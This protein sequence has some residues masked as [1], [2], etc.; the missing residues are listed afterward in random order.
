[1]PL[2]DEPD[3]ITAQNI[4]DAFNEILL[5]DVNDNI[6]WGTDAQPTYNG[7]IV[8]GLTGPAGAWYGGSTAGIDPTYDGTSLPRAGDNMIEA[9][10]IY[11]TLLAQT[12][13]YTVV[14]KM[15]ASLTLTG[16]G[17]V[18]DQ[19]QKAY[20]SDPYKQT[21]TT[22]QG[23][24]KSGKLITTGDL[25][26]FFTLLDAQYLVKEANAYPNPDTICHTSCHSSCH[27]SRIRR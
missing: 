8:G 4:V 1:M 19:T 14:R 17:I 26:T 9:A 20:M 2:T 13:L 10:K 6:I 12:R 11:S 22:G 23:N 21:L 16:T 27:S 7:H 25:E 5:A 3:G 15:H 24:I 18:Y